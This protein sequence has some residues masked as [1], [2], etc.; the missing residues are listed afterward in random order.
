MGHA[1]GRQVIRTEKENEQ[2]TEQYEEIAPYF[3]GMQQ[4]SRRFREDPLR[5]F[6]G[7]MGSDGRARRGGRH[8]RQYLR[9]Y[10]G[11]QAGGDRHAFG[12]G[13][14]EKARRAFDRHRLPCAAL[15]AGVVRP[16][17]GDRSGRRHRSVRADRPIRKGFHHPRR[18]SE[19]AASCLRKR[20]SRAYGRAALCLR[21]HRR[22]LQ[23]FLQL[24]RDPADPR[25][26][27]QS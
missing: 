11:G 6:A 8:R 9:L 27:P 5:V 3:A 15:L 16:D 1:V 25:P 23:Q 18:L 24:L 20:T 4:E 21:P 22:R 13:A 26:L 17:G 10:R 19:R 14:A 2:E 7:G 12:N